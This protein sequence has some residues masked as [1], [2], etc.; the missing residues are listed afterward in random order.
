MF[1]TDNSLYDKVA[2]ISFFPD[3]V[4]KVSPRISQLHISCVSTSLN[5][6]DKLS[7][8]IQYMCLDDYYATIVRECQYLY[9]TI[10]IEDSLDLVL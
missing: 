1:S 5:A 2:V 8:I 6:F 3:V 7:L 4:Y 10:I 9:F